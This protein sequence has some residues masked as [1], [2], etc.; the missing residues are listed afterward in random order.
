MAG[1]KMAGADIAP[2][3]SGMTMTGCYADGVKFTESY[4]SDGK[5][6]YVDDNGADL[7]NWFEQQGLFCTFY[8][9]QLGACFTVI[10]KGANCFEFHAVKDQEGTAIDRDSWTSVGWD[11]SKPATCDP[12]DKT[13]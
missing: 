5:I 1:E 13:V 8:V 11:I 10:R 2:V 4:K 12:A 9:S 3:F 7:G 6:D